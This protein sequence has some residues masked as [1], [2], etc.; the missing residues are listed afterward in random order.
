MLYVRMLLSIVVSLYT[1]RVVLQTLG[2]EDYGIYGVVGGV[3]SMF[4]FLNA[5]M[6]GATSRFLT[7]E[8]GKADK[9]VNSKGGLTSLEK[10][11][12]SAMIIH[13]GIALTVFVLAMTIGLWFL[14]NKLVIPEGRMPAAYCVFV[15]SIL[16][17]FVSVT[18]VPYNAAIIAHEKMDVYA[19]VELLNV[20][21]KLAIVYLLL[22]GNLD[23]LIFYA[24]LQLSV[25]CIVAMVYRVYCITHFEETH[26]HWLWDKDY[27][28]PMLVFSGWDLFGNL[29]LTVKQQ[30]FTFLINMFF[31]VVFNAAA[32][33]AA[34]IEG[35]I[36]GLC[37]NVV[38]A[39]R[40]Q[41]IKQYSA[42]NEDASINYIY[43][44]AK[45]ATIMLLVIAVPVV[46]ETDFLL[47]LWLGTPP[48]YAALFCQLLM[49]A[50]C[51]N[52]TT[53][54]FNVGIHATGRMKSMSFWTG[55]CFIG[56][57]PILYLCYKFDT[58]VETAFLLN[59]ILAVV[60]LAIR[61]VILH[62]YIKSFSY[63]FFFLKV[64]MPI[65][66]I[67]II[68]ILSTNVVAVSLEEGLVRCMMV[69]VI[70][71]VVGS[72]SFLYVGLNKEQ[73]KRV[74][75]FIKSKI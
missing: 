70:N 43:Q 10:T 61:G 13:V 55:I 41:I 35:T 36:L 12:S 18:Q 4:S 49:I 74:L 57:I 56:I 11:F 45:I 23:K 14:N 24:I 42:G 9:D 59:I 7:F 68:L 60:T 73:R 63:K 1:S 72:V 51:T 2:V 6:S 32:S 53:C 19:Y 17:M 37:N 71:I 62:D 75:S 8:I 44:S 30:G 48:E 34:V 28:K 64:L 22:I 39:Y 46:Y 69:F 5:A 15:C 67:A 65:F 58:P 47:K 20:F 26:F 31:G 27:L 16:S 3:V 38:M 50:A 54:A 52:P 25:S 66:I 21:L 40:P 33:I 29:S